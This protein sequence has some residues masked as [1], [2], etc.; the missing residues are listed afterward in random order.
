MPR[1]LSQRGVDFE[2]E[3][4]F[5]S[6]FRSCE[7]G[8]RVLRSGTHMPKGGFVAAKHPSKWGR[9]CEILAGALRVR[10]QTAITSSFQIQITHRLKHWTPDFLSFETEYGMHNLSSIKCFKNVSNSS[11]MGVRLRHFSS[12]FAQSSSNGHNF[13]V[14]TPICTPFEALD[15]WLPKIWNNI[16]YAWNELWKVIEMCPTVAKMGVRLWLFH[17]WCARWR[18]LKHGDFATI[19][20]LRNECTGL[21]N[22][23]R[24]PKGRF[25]AAKHPSKW[26]LCC[27]MEDFKAWR[28]RNHF[29]AAKRVYEP[30]KWHSCAMGS[31]RSCKNFHRGGWAAA[32]P[33]CSR[34]AFS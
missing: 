13:F 11:E 33:F 7:I 20:Q 24:V 12:L 22:G 3:G 14:S 18:I 30:M 6:P 16:W 21:P 2:K 26:R 8:V 27:K 23:T 32:K 25:T 5:R 4:N 17:S 31:L 1:A 10:L 29:A 9:G 19:S 28:L 34:K 15:S